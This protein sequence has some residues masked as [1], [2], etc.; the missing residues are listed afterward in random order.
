M[1]KTTLNEEK[2]VMSCLRKIIIKSDLMFE[3]AQNMVPCPSCWMSPSVSVSQIQK[4]CQGRFVLVDWCDSKEL[5][6]REP[7]TVF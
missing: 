1:C 6:T 5:L 4:V 2:F 3:T 7:K